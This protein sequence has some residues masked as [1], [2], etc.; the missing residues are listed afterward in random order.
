MWHSPDILGVLERLSREL[1]ELSSFSAGDVVVRGFG[2]LGY[3]EFLCLPNGFLVS[4]FTGERSKVPESTSGKGAH[5][6]KVPEWDELLEFLFHR[7]VVVSGFTRQA[8]NRWSVELES[9]DA[10]PLEGVSPMELLVK[11]LEW[12][13]YERS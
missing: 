9:G 4:L 11:L 10:L 13:V 12:V 2:D 3:E 6:F 7:G 5:L 1:S 8:S